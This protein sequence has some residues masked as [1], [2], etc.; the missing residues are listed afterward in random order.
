M[1]TRDA[2]VAA[3]RRVANVAWLEARAPAAFLWS[4]AVAVKPHLLAQYASMH[5]DM[6]AEGLYRFAVRDQIKAAGWQG[7]APALRV[8][9]E[10]F[11]ATYLALLAEIERADEARGSRSALHA[12]PTPEA[13][14]Q[15]G[16]V[17]VPA[18]AEMD[19]TVASIERAWAGDDGRPRKRSK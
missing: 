18:S 9:L 2:A 6:P 7:C 16:P 10:V 12:V 4:D 11:R 8:A 15:R 5:R 19:A 14:R 17:L 3:A 13:T 1:M